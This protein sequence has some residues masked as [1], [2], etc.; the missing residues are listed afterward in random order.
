MT[1]VARNFFTLAILFALGGM[2]LGLHMSISHDYL[3]RPVHA[4][5]MAAGWLMSAVFAFFYHLVPKAGT[6]RMAKVHFWMHALTGIG[7][8]VGLFFLLGGNEDFEPL[9]AVASLGFYGAMVLFAFIAL[10]A[11]YRS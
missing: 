1:G 9:V 3:Q 4:H 5:A 6:S 11:L 10:G 8:M 2:A 7:L